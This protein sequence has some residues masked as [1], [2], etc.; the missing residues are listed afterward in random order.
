MAFV[1]VC[2]ISKFSVILEQAV[3]HD[4]LPQSHSQYENKPCYTV[5]PRNWLYIEFQL[6]QK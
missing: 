2:L 3:M 6:Q 4:N 1:Y 5:T